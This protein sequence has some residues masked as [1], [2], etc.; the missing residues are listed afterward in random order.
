MKYLVQFIC[1]VLLYCFAAAQI[2]FKPFPQHVTYFK[3]VIQPSHIS[4]QQMDDRVKVFYTAWEQ[5]YIRP[6]KV[7]DQYYVWSGD[8]TAKK[9]SISEGQGYGMIIMTLMAGN[10]TT[11]QQ[12]YNGLYQY[13][14]AHTSENSNYFMAWAQTNSFKNADGSSAT[15]GDLDIAYS[16]L[17]ADAQWGSSHAI[18]YLAEAKAMLGA[19]MQQEINATTFSILL[20]NSVERDSKDYFDMRSSDFMPA[21]C[22]VFNN[23]IHNPQWEKVTDKNYQLFAFLQKHFSPDAG[24]VPD[25]IRHI[26]Q[27]PV[28]CGANYLESKYDGQYNYNAC[29]VPWRIATDYIVNGDL[30]SKIFVEKINRWIRSTTDN[31]PDNISAGYTLQGNDIGGRNFE[32]LSFISSFAVSAMVDEKNQRW[33][34][35]L[36]DYMIDFKLNQFDYYDNTI[37]MIALIILSGNYWIP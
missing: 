16:L 15:D 37:K 11:T 27:N 25:F 32:A 36:W 22:K 4:Q 24:L 14:K 10:D 8:A 17:L 28:P 33:L 18:N 9:Q 35:S 30:L 5:R 29:R 31:N 20:S 21:H 3:G 19:I 26:N 34:N 23:I 6:A 7:N 12:I 2:S 13:Y 1:L